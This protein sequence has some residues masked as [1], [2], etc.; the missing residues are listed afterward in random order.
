MPSPATSSSSSPPASVTSSSAASVGSFSSAAAKVNPVTGAPYSNRYQKLLSKRKKLPVWGLKQK[1]LEALAKR[2]VVIVAAAPG[3]GKSTQI[4]QFVVEAGYGSREKQIACTQPRRLV[5]TSLSRRVAQEMDVKI[6]EE[7]GYSVQFEEYGSPKTIL[8]YMTDGVLLREVQSDRFLEKYRVIILDEVHL[9]TLATDVLLAYLKKMVVMNAQSGL[10]LVLL[11]A[12]TEAK[13][14]RDYFDGS[15]IVQATSTPYAVENIYVKEQV[16]DFVGAA[17]EK[18]AQILV[19]E[20]PG[21]ILVFLTGEEEIEACCWR[22]KKVVSDLGDKVGQINICPLHSTLTLA[23]QKLVFK[24]TP[25]ASK[26][27]PIGRKV[28]VSTDIAESSLTLNGIVYVIDSG[29]TKQKVYNPC[30]HVESLLFV[31]APKASISRR[32]GCARRSAPGKCFKLYTE[33]F[34]DDAQPQVSPEIHR[35]NLRDTILQLKKLGVSDL[36]HLDFL[37]PPPAETFQQAYDALKCLGALD[38][39]GNLTKL[40]EQMTEFPLD[41]QMSKMIIASPEFHCSNEVLSIAAMLS[42]PNCFLRPMESQI[43]ADEAKAKF[44]HV[45][46]DH[47][48][49]LNVYHAYKQ[50]NGDASWCEKNYISQ[51]TLKLADSVRSQLVSIMHKLNL[52]LCSTDINSCDYFNNIRKSILAGYFM[53]AARIED[54]GHYLTLKSNHFVDLHPSTCLTSKPTWVV[55]NDF[56][57]ASR[58]FIRIVTDVRGEWLLDIAPHY[59]QVSTLL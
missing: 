40:G 8:K 39:E 46:G 17:I 27:G 41:P 32:S 59:F 9:R 26:K 42:V 12:Q 52:Q 53:Q 36:L 1:F 18:V 37:D 10:K 24:G 49:L 29:F 43:S 3:S 51:A 33:K 55:Y 14:F 30:Q 31:P 47:F 54:S 57:L 28:V 34:F 45:M 25:P 2:E 13:I 56:V 19:S 58:N 38:T 48:A 23:M 50:E 4:P 35:A 22:L 15:Q 5:A 16:R 44:N 11:S 7:V 21:D 20:P 6:G